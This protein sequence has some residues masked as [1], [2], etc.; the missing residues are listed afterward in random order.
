MGAPFRS[1]CLFP[2]AREMN[3]ARESDRAV[4]VVIDDDAEIR[5]TLED[6]INSVGLEAETF[7]SV[8]HFLERK[9]SR[10]PGCMV[11]D[12]RLPGKS[13]LDFFDDLAKANVRLPVVFISGHADV[14]MSVR[15]MKAGAVEFLTKPVRHQDLLDAIQLAMA[16][17]RER[18]NDE[19]N[20]IDISALYDTLTGREREVFKL[21]ARGRSNKQIAAELKIGTTTVKLHRGQVMRKMKAANL[22]ELVR[23]ADALE[24]S[25]PQV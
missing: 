15:A 7:A 6:L 18:R 17:D 24:T 16:K 3:I 1:T 25:R 22:A 21:V 13:G 20:L 12:V 9:G 14:P 2:K 4:V 23:I 8:Q 11:L 5:E 10:H 19:Q